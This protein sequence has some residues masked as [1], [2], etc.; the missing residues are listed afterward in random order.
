MSMRPRKRQLL[1]IALPCTLALSACSREPATARDAASTTTKSAAQSTMTLDA[2]KLPP[3]IH[4][5]TS[6][7]DA[8]ADPCVDLNA[9]V[10][11]RWLAD[12]PIPNDR[13]S[14]G[15][16][17]MMEEHSLAVQR[18]MAEQ[19]AAT[20][21]ATGIDKIVGDFW[22]TGMDEA[23]I[24]AAGIE[25]IKSRLAE[26][27][28]LSDPASIGSYLRTS[29][30]RGEGQVFAFGALPDFKDSSVNMA[31]VVQG[32]LGLDDK[33]YYF[34]KDK[35]DKLQAYQTHIARLIELAGVPVDAAAAQARD[36]IAF[37]TRLARASK[38]SEEIAR[39][40]SLYYNPV[41]PADA[42]KLTPNFSWSQFF[43]SQG[44]ALPQTFSLAMP[45]F[46]QEFD[47]MM[48]DVP[49]EQ[50][51][52]YL[53][54]HLL[55][56]AAPYLSTPFVQEDFDFHKRVMTGQQEMSPRWKRVLGAIEDGAGEAMG[57]LYVKV[58]FPPESKARMTTLVNNLNTA[59]K[60]RI[61]KLEW[62]S[63][64]TKQK[65]LTKANAF[66]TKIGYPD[67]WR[68]FSA[69]EDQSRQL[70]RQCL[71]RY[72][73]QSRVGDGQDRQTRR[74]DRMEHHTADGERQLL[75]LEQRDHVPGGDPATAVLRLDRR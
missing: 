26:I 23:K 61:E 63:D 18:Q 6:E 20:T 15:P 41:T 30:A 44:M 48:A 42:D 51:Q 24:N 11:A 64:A 46:E 53:R 29:A 22:A 4:F 62:M 34:D 69:P 60:A 43:E 55:D 52:A 49:V 5:A 75:R 3:L 71:V 9:H 72:Q 40:V 54:A 45:V 56:S 57:Q 58:V 66:S 25:P 37:E 74:Q 13:S 33:G 1:L 21:D 35:R 36:T 39:D 28:A 7:F 10:N 19:A 68:D 31:F 27:D 67:K 50:W 17:E 32:G 73:V 47:K 38:S 70:P 8:S 12:H 16:M 14:W 2:S 65:A 59:L